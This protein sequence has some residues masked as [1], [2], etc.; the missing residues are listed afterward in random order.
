VPAAAVAAVWIAVQCA[1]EIV[2]TDPLMVRTV[3]EEAYI[4]L[5][6]GYR[7][8]AAAAAAVTFPFLVAAVAGVVV[9]VQRIE[10]ILPAGS[11]AADPPFAF[12]PSRTA[13]LG[14]WAT[15]SLTL[16]L[17]VAAIS[18]KAAGGGAPGGAGLGRLA[19]TLARLLRSDG[20]VLGESLLTA[21]AA[22]LIT[23]ALAWTACG[24]ARRSRLLSAGLLVLCVTLWLTP[25]PLLGFG[26]K[27]YFDAGMTAEDGVFRMTGFHPAYPPV[28]SLVYDQ[29]SPVPVVWAAVLRLFPLAV[30][31]VWPAVRAVPNELLDLA[32]TDGLSVAGY[33]RRVVAPVAGPAFGVAAVA[34][35]ALALGEVSAG[36]V[37]APP[38]Y[39]A[40]VLDLF[41]QM[42]YGT[43]ATVCGLCLLQLVATA[44]G[45][46]VAWLLWISRSRRTTRTSPLPVPNSPARSG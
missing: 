45:L 33:F 25:G 21:I 41:A 20:A 3:A 11:G 26:L 9:F 32:A 19:D 17:P 43:D 29:P 36:K 18:W 16:G 44:T 39:R 38:G 5:A 4:Q 30:A 7:A 15:L 6:V 42:H 34:V 35:A 37:V 22:G 27:E 14:V 46:I 40:F 13:F 23:A 1:T 24:L 2:I 31:V 12:G 10:R 28:R 8:G